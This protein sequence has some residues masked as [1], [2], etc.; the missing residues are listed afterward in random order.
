MDIVVGGGGR[1][2][3]RVCECIEGVRLG[4]AAVV[5]LHSIG[6]WWCWLASS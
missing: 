2:R 3:R 1:R 5:V 4:L 6:G